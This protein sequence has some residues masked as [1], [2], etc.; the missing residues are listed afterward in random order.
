MVQVGKVL[1]TQLRGPELGSLSAIYKDKHV[2]VTSV[3]GM[4]MGRS[5]ELT[6]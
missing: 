2:P 5:L 6:S 1:A 4:E 3:L